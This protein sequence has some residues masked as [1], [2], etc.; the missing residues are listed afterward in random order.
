M[1]RIIPNYP[2][3]MEKIIV[4]LC[5]KQFK[6]T[7]SLEVKITRDMTNLKLTKNEVESIKNELADNLKTIRVNNVE[8]CFSLCYVSNQITKK[9][10]LF[11]NETY[12]IKIELEFD[13]FHS[14][15]R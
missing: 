10:K 3:L 11:S 12:I 4:N 6:L 9:F 14:A 13:E 7:T 2:K 8:Y 1:S 5:R 15:I